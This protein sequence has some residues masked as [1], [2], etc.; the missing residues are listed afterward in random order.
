M[1][2]LSFDTLKGRV[3]SESYFWYRDDSFRQGQTV[4]GRPV[5]EYF[6]I[7]TCCFYNPMSQSQCE[8]QNKLW[9]LTDQLLLT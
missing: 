5:N 2:D 6:P 8:A 1:S 4:T 3:Y 7:S 9:I